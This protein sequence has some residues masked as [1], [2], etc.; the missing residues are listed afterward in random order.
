MTDE[1]KK[2]FAS[3][4]QELGKYS[5]AGSKV[6]L[7]AEAAQIRASEK[8]MV[9]QNVERLRQVAHEA[10]EVPSSDTIE[11]KHS[12]EPNGLSNMSWRGGVFWGTMGETYVMHV[13]CSLQVALQLTR[14][15]KYSRIAMEGGFC[16]E[17]GDIL[18]STSEDVAARFCTCI[19][20]VRTLLPYQ[21]KERPAT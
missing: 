9:E 18:L 15:T 7:A 16:K 10:E 19:R 8:E 3:R 4:L 2:M 11:P 1:Q 14:A 12:F 17:N 6:L 13:I 21:Q 20:V 5:A